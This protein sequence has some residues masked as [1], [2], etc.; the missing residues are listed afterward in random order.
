MIR[1]SILAMYATLFAGG[2]SLL[3]CPSQPTPVERGERTAT[4]SKSESPVGNESVSASQKN[5]H[6]IA[7][8]Q[9]DPQGKSSAG[10][11]TGLALPLWSAAFEVDCR[12]TNGGVWNPLLAR[13]ARETPRAI[14]NGPIEN[15]DLHAFFLADFD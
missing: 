11:K 13:I 10:D 4:P 7:P 15:A 1:P 5:Q 2:T 3:G 6:A 12:G 8:V 9:S 14:A